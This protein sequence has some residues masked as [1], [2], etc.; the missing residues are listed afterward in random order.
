MSDDSILLDFFFASTQ[1]YLNK[2]FDSVC[3]EIV[4]QDEQ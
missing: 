1:N 3:G 2:I 4:S